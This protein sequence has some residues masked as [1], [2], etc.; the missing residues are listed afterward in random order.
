MQTDD[1]MKSAG[2]FASFVAQTQFRDID[3]SVVEHIKKM[4]LKQVMSML[5]GSTTQSAAKLLPYVQENPGRPEAGVY[6]YG[7]KVD[8]AQAAL[9]NGFSSH[10]SEMEDDQFPGATS[11]VTVWPALL[12]VAEW[13]KLSGQEIVTAL[14][15]GQ[16]IQNRIAW[17]VS[18]GTDA[19]GIC[20]LPFLGVYGG[21]AACAKA[22]GLTEEQI[23]AS[24]GLAMVSGVGYAYEMGTD[25]H[26]WESA[27]VCRNA[28]LNAIMAKNGFTSAPA[29]ENMMDRLTGGNKNL[30]FGKMTEALGKPPYYTNNTWIKKWGFCFGTHVYVDILADLMKA[31]GIGAGDVEEVAVHFDPN[32]KNILDRPNPTTVDDSRFSI[33]HILAYQLLFGKCTIDTCSNESLRDQRITAARK[34]IR[35][36]HHPEEP[37][38]MAADNGKL[39]VKLKNGRVFKGAM[40]QPYGAP[41]H[42]L[43]M[44]QVLSIY[45]NDSKGVLAQAQ[46]ER[47]IEIVLDIENTPNL[48]ELFNICTYQRTV[49]DNGARVAELA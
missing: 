32:R 1:G 40:E 38:R 18:P 3:A 31:N 8:V 5:V 28:I 36:I 10:A 9:M 48:Q 7:L 19:I 43:T 26:Y 49:K 25:A 42:P 11:D 34:K 44:E 22:L 23:R 27:L 17:W 14:Y 13:Q 37:L 30:Q 45:R 15:V 29:I 16:E 39:D 4:T 35:V 21:T 24:L 20:N 47:T 46:I 33:Q 6:G 2:L 41:L 12:A